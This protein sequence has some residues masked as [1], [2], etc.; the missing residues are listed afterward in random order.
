[1]LETLCVDLK[2]LGLMGW[3]GQSLWALRC[4]LI[5][6]KE[7]HDVEICKRCKRA[8]NDE[9]LELMLKIMNGSEGP[10]GFAI[11]NTAPMT[12]LLSIQW[13]MGSLTWLV[14]RALY[15]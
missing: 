15:R 8:L 4:H 10:V 7:K 12:A 5:Q 1:M 9:R 14:G 3:V 11:G 13:A 6:R 2:C